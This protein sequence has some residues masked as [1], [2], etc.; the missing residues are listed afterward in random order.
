MS[1]A[2]TTTATA[3]YD[4][5]A[6]QILST[7]KANSKGTSDRCCA[8]VKYA[9]KRD[10]Y[11]ALTN[12]DTKSTNKT[13]V[14][15]VQRETH[16]KENIYES[17]SQCC[18]TPT[19]GCT[20]CHIHA[21]V[22]P[23]NLV[24]MTD[25]V[26]A[27]KATADHE[28][29]KDMGVRGAKSIKKTTSGKS[30]SVSENSNNLSFPPFITAIFTNG[31][32][33]LISALESYAQQLIFKPQ[34]GNSFV[35]SAPIAPTFVAPVSPISSIVQSVDEINLNETVEPIVQ[36]EEVGCTEIQSITGTNYYWD[37]N[38]GDVYDCVL[39]NDGDLEHVEIGKLIEV[40]DA[41]AFIIHEDK[42]YTVLRP[43]TTCGQFICHFSKKKFD[44]K[45]QPL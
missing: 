6:K 14:Y 19:S 43:D 3:V 15:I 31:D 16:G 28:Y 32:K 1:A 25:L 33:N 9:T 12:I 26:G 27:V 44:D 7:G 36:E 13:V 18:K 34:T 5:V 21:K 30:G 29:Y 10:S 11:D 2:T 39:N 4:T 40:N 38:S 22:K 37:E 17:Y 24:K 8:A 20:M 42:K 23:G 41:D 35:P 45:F